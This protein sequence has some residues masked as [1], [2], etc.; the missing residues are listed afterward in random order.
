M[1]LT[2]IR[3]NF[4][5]FPACESVKETAFILLGKK[6]NKGRGERK[7]GGKGKGKVKGR[8]EEF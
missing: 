6:I 5:R 7:E 3:A 2:I 8:K 4:I 1:E